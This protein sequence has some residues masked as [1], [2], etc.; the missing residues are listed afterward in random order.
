MQT[1]TEAQRREHR[2]DLDTV[3]SHKNANQVI[4]AQNSAEGEQ[5]STFDRDSLKNTLFKMCMH[6]CVG[7]NDTAQDYYCLISYH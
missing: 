3:H 7:F 6:V 2:Q 1:Q 4:F 5:E